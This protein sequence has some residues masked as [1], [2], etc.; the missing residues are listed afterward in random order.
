M[1]VDGLTIAAGGGIEIRMLDDRRG[2]ELPVSAAQGDLWEL[3]EYV[4]NNPKGIYEYA[5]GIWVLRNPSISALSFDV[6]GS[7]IGT[8]NPGDRV[9][10]FVTPR[11]F[12]IEA[13]L[14]GGIAAALTPP[15]MV[16]DFEVQ[17]SRNGELINVGYI[18]FD[19]ESYNGYF[20]PAS[21]APIKVLRGDALLVFAPFNVDPGLSDI[22]FTI[23][24]HLSV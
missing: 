15:T 2:P 13:S 23:C 8:P 12:E 16:Q 22:S 20:L 24:G 9:M 3:T 6:S 18:R 21:S 19:A 7:V 1:L 4:G 10:F 5:N 17:I 11:T 14:A